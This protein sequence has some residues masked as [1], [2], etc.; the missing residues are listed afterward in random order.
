MAGN[1]RF[2]LVSCKR[3]NNSYEP[4]EIGTC[5]L[6][7]NIKILPDGRSYISTTGQRR[8]KIKKHWDCD[9]YKMGEIEWI[10][11][12]DE[13]IDNITQELNALR[14]NFVNLLLSQGNLNESLN[15]IVQE[16]NELST[17]D[18]NLFVWSLI[19]LVPF[20]SNLCQYMLSLLSLKERIK[21]L[22]LMQ[23]KLNRT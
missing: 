4:F 11:D 22:K 17:D 13:Q 15:N 7:T 18:P 16:I 8:F 9:G 5:L 14:E 23:P 12:V 21:A 2:G 19:D 20:P 3:N 10:D 1:Q 6:I